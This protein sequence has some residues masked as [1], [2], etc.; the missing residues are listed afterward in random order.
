MYSNEPIKSRNR[1]NQRDTMHNPKLLPDSSEAMYKVSVVVP[2]YNVEKY[3]V[4]CAESLFKQTLDGIQFIFVDD[5]SP[6]KSVLL[7]EQTLEQFPQRKPHTIILHHTHNLGLPTA[8]A[9]GLTHVK[10]PYVAY[11]DSDDY[12]EL[13]MYAKLYDC[14][15]QNDSD[16]VVCGRIIHN[17]DGKE[18]P[19]FDK[20]L[21]GVSVIINYLYGRLTPLVWSRLTRTD[22]YRRVTFPT[23]NYSEDMVQTAQ[24]FTFASR[25]FSLNEALY[26]YIRRPLSL[27]TDN[28]QDM[29]EKKIQQ[30]ITNFRLYHDFIMKHHLAKEE[31]FILA[32]AS[33]RFLYLPLIARWSIRDKYIHTFP[34]INFR[35][36]INRKIPLRIMLLHLSVLLGLYPIIRDP[37]RFFKKMFLRLTQSLLRNSNDRSSQ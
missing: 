2:I 24:L 4:R 9:T 22:I 8:R 5:A 19:Q 21:K 16:M 14:A 6:D 12:V 31:D 18:Y 17:F 15:V 32:K 33:I 28:R 26:H 37:Y 13:T 20:P 36:L 27:T 23:E 35:L 30:N 1:S 7:L 29:I 25:V 34:E 3:I 11:C 10:A